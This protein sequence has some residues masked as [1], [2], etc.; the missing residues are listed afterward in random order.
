[1]KTL[2]ELLGVSV[3]TVSNAYSKPD[4]LSPDL[5]EQILAKG[6]DLGYCGPSAAGRAL[7]SGKTDVCGFLFGGELADAFGDPYT[8]AFLAGLS[9]SAERY[10]ASVLLL[11]AAGEEEDAER[12]LLQR[13]PIDAIVICSAI[14]DHP[15]TELL[16]QRGV[17]V[18]GAQR[19]EEGDWVAIND[20]K[21]GRLVG[22]H[23]AKLG[24]RNVVV[25]VPGGLPEGGAFELDPSE[26]LAVAGHFA[27]ERV[28][29]LIEK[30]PDASVRVVCGGWK[31]REGGR[32]AAALALDVQDRPTAVVAMSDVLALGVL[33]ALRERGLRPGRQVSVVGFDDIPDAAAAG[34]TTVRQPT[35]D[36]GRYAGR[37]AMD[38]DYPQRQITLPIE[39]V[40][41]SST[42]P[43]PK[44]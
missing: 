40:V 33:D 18:V 14:T 4:R 29:G 7:R 42:G 43:A 5:R 38:P 3:T 30:L 10:G 1:M 28:Q 34:L 8:I 6:K 23:L 17:R 15:A 32:T 27:A 31:P 36:K 44:L 16:A 20:I 35:V 12:Q 2:A 26:V 37:L 11:R 25:V 24:H 21:A 41:R 39:L 19:T 13:A 9:E 22:K